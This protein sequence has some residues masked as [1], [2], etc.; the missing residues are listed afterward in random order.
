MDLSRIKRVLAQSTLAA[1][2]RVLQTFAPSLRADGAALD[3]QIAALIRLGNLL[4]EPKTHE[5]P[6]PLA[7]ATFRHQ[8]RI[9]DLSP[10]P[11]V[12]SEEL[13][14]QINGT[15]LQARLYRPAGAPGRPPAL[16]YFHG[17]GFVI[18][19][20]DSHDGVC[21]WLSRGSGAAV[22]SV[23]YRMAPE[24]PFPAAVDD[25]V[26]SYRWA[27]EQRERLGLGALG[28]GG[29]SA[30]GCLAAVVCQQAQREGLPQPAMQLLVYPV[31]HV[32]SQLPSREAFARDLFL[33]RPTI[34]WFCDQYLPPPLP[35]DDPR[36]SPLLAPELTGLAPALVITAGFDPL[37]DEGERYAERLREAGVPVEHHR[38]QTLP[39]GFWSM[40]GVCDEARR[41]VLRM[42]RRTGQ[43]LASGG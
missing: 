43:L 42:A 12:A 29:D 1:P 32:G 19:D 22:L 11:D 37:R 13:R 15:S 35:R 40:G 31:T 39:H 4:R 10:P 33:E 6:V 9:V 17:G 8:T 14:L 21:R 3:P 38:A 24:H 18:G 2:P 16:V 26:A 25:A 5:Q 23:A 7:R 27:L 20:L 28:V 41:W 30:G 34:D 36:A